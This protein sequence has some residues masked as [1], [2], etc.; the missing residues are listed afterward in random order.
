MYEASLHHD[1][2]LENVAHEAKAKPS[3]SVNL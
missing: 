3:P 1:E 2:V